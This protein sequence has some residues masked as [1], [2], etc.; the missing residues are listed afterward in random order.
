MHPR[1]ADGARQAGIGGDQQNQAP[2]ARDPRQ[3]ARHETAVRCA[4]MAIHKPRSTRQTLRGLDW[5]WGTLGVGEEIQR[6]NGWPTLV[7][8]EPS[9]QRG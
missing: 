7:V 2:A 9:G 4:E 6:R 3:L 1:R 5:V 8:V